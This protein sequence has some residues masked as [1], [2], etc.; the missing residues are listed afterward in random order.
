VAETSLTAFYQTPEKS[1]GGFV[2]DVCETEDYDFSNEMTDIPVEEGENIADNVV[3]NQDEITINAFIADVKFDGTESGRRQS[4]HEA[5]L[6]LKRARQPLD[7]VLG[8]SKNPF[9][10][11]V[12]AS[13][14]PSRNKGNGLDLAFTMTLKS[15][16][17]AKSQT[18]KIG[19]EKLPET[20]AKEQAQSAS[21]MGTEGKEEGTPD[22]HKVQWQQYI[23]G[24]TGAKREDNIAFYEDTFKEKYP[25]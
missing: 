12:I 2:I 15:V 20:S 10:N 24:M 7:V 3:E 25:E 21:E 18:T 11:M 4:A 6:K 1:V 22:E 5:L 9:K 13:Y 23:R 17:I 14:H 16:K 8:L 19:A